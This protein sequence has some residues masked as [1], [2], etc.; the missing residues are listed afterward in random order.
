MKKHSVAE[1]KKL[2][3]TIINRHTGIK[4]PDVGH[5][6]LR[7]LYHRKAGA[8]APDQFTEDRAIMARGETAAHRHWF[9]RLFDKELDQ[10][11][12]ITLVEEAFA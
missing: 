10:R 1:M 5:E 8:T 7:K 11:S 9:A 3:F 4:K 12:L 2:R 6:T